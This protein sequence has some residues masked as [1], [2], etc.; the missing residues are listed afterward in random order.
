DKAAEGRAAAIKRFLSAYE[1]LIFLDVFEAWQSTERQT[2]SVKISKPTADEQYNAWLGELGEPLTNLAEQLA[3]QFNLDLASIK[4]IAAKS[5]GDQ[6]IIW[7]DCRASLKPTMD[8]LA[9]LLEPRREW[10]ALDPR[11]E[12]QRQEIWS[13][14]VLP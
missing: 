1:G 13:Y 11:D 2:V 10:Q 8:G 14:L 9:Q 6:A 5:N 7:Q 12:K 4:Q 3:G